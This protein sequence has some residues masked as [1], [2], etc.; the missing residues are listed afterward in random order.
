M[1]G[2]QEILTFLASLQRKL[3]GFE[4]VFSWLHTVSFFPKCSILD[5]EAEF[6]GHSEWVPLYLWVSSV[7]L[8]SGKCLHPATEAP[9]DS[10]FLSLLRISEFFGFQWQTFGRNSACFAESLADVAITRL[11]V[12]NVVITRFFVANVAITSFLGCNFTH[13][14]PPGD[15]L[16]L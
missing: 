9:V 5:L 7:Q 11:F 13:N 2:V 15:K 1:G 8:L 3:L 4:V 12:A 6:M 14:T 16:G 10:E